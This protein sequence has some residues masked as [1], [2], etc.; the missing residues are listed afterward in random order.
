M[1]AR[2]R[3]EP[4]GVGVGLRSPHFTHILENN[5]QISWFEA[6]SENY[7]GLSTSPLSGRPLR[8]LELIRKNYP[9]VL[10]GVSMSIGSSDPLDLN[11]LKRLKELCAAIEPS[12]ISDH[13]CWT[14]I[15]GEN[16]HDL[17]PLPYTE[18]ALKHVVQRISAAQDILGRRLAFE[19]VSAYLSY[20]H[21]EMTEWEF[22]AEISK[23]ADCDLL[24]DINN[25]YVS[26]VNQNFNPVD[27]INKIPANRVAQ[28]HLAGHSRS[29]EMLIDTHDHPVSK[30]VWDLYEFAIDS[31]GIKPTL[32]EWDANIPD[33]SRLEIE[34]RS[35]ENIL[36]K[37]KSQENDLKLTQ[38]SIR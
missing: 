14:S 9:I 31:F 28:I 29:G 38:T 17:L 24:L 21:S 32:I 3:H 6:I 35:A 12:W 33:F 8:V 13:L 2:I 11:Y 16:L 4:L 25:V 18:E 23:Q 20:E 19:N 15:E 34:A 30:S 1:A 7:M 10:H 26:S 22:L 36:E 37:K 27:F 5:P